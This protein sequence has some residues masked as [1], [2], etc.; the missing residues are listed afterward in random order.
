MKFSEI[1]NQASDLLR[2][3]G[4]MTYRALTRE[5]G[6]DE[7]TLEDLKE[8]LLFLHAEIAEVDGRG[9]VWNGDGSG[10]ETET[11]AQSPAP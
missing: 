2:Q 10:E 4:R 3:Q 9:L 5:F 6:L 1:V 7:E 8:E 11:P